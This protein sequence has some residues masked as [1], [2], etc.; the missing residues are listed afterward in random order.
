LSVTL[1]I[2]DILQLLPQAYPFVLV[3]R[4]IDYQ[5]EHSLTALK[6]VT[7]NEPF[8]PGHFPRKPVMPGV[9]I[10]E[11]MAQTCGLLAVQMSGGKRAD[12]AL[13]YFAGVDNAR[14]K[15]QVAPGDQMQI[16][17]EFV[18]SKRSIWKFSVRATVEG[19][20]A[21]SAE[22]TCALSIGGGDGGDVPE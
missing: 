17:A 4:V 11:A 14:F 2:Q 12:D 20:I 22:V 19:Q 13:L 16:H 3:D 7:Y 18:R 15:R 8:F 1:D 10:L 5:P 9:L 21:C 6:N